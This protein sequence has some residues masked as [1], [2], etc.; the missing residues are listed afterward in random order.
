MTNQNRF[1]I[2]ILRSSFYYIYKYYS[3]RKMMAIDEVCLLS[4]S[5]PSINIMINGDTHKWRQKTKNFWTM[6]EIEKDTYE[7]DYNYAEPK[8]SK[9][10]IMDDDSK[11]NR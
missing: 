5:S 8:E 7:I 3:D 10:Q 6:V 1:C 11:W 9:P 4:N 2:G